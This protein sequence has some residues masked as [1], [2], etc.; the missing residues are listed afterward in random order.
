M[1]LVIL[2][3]PFKPTGRGGLNRTV[4][5]MENTAYVRAAMR[6]CLK[7]GEAPFASHALYTLDGVLDDNIPEERK[8]GMR[9][10]FAW[11]ERAEATVVYV[12][13]GVT[14]GM[15]LGIARAEKAGR[16]VERRTLRGWKR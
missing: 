2:E 13:L 8:L 3:S 15:E 12:D 11:G 5:L 4:E 1:R 14:E 7:C 6:D 16:P 9:A 10:G